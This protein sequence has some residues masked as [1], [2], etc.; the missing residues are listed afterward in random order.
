MVLNKRMKALVDSVKG[1]SQ[2]KSLTQR[3]AT[4][5]TDGVR[6]ITY[7]TQWEVVSLFVERQQVGGAWSIKLRF[8]EKVG[9]AFYY[10]G[11]HGATLGLAVQDFWRQAEAGQFWEEGDYFRQ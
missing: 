2:Y 5:L 6:T 9:R 3:I 4:A 8:Y 7:T 11:G 1:W 10:V